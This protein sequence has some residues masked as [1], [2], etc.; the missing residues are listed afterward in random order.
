MRVLLNDFSGGVYTIQAS[1]ELGWVPDAYLMART[2]T[3]ASAP[4]SEA[5]HV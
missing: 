4:N 1:H 2:F 5:C 3:P